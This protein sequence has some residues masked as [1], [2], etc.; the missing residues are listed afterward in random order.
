MLEQRQT[1][2]DRLQERH[3]LEPFL[4]KDAVILML[5]S[6]PP[7]KKRWSMD[8]YY[9]NINNDMW[10]IIGMIFYGDR[11]HFLTPTG[12]AFCKDAIVKFLTDKHIALYDTAETVLRLNGDASDKFLDVLTPTDVKALLDKLPSCRAIAATGQKAVEILTQQFATAEPRIGSYVP[13][14]HRGRELRIY[15][16]PSTSRAY[17]LKPEKK[18]E[19]YSAMFREIGIL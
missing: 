2:S 15:R 5:G 4:P 7:P 16:M 17:P 8:F 12:K 1:T 14:V 11:D 3:P 9:P 6:F 18:A 13:T 10:R 19:A